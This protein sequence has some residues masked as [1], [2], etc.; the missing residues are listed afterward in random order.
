MDAPRPKRKHR[1]MSRDEQRAAGAAAQGR[2]TGNGVPGRYERKPYGTGSAAGQGQ[3]AWQAPGELPGAAARRGS[4]HSAGARPATGRHS[5]LSGSS[6]SDLSRYQQMRREREGFSGEGGHG[7]ARRAAAGGSPRGRRRLG[8]KVF[9]GVV[10]SLLVFVIGFSLVIGAHMGSGITAETR[11]ALTPSFPG[12]PF[13]MLLVGTD[14]SAEREATGATDGLYRTDSIMLTRVDPLAA[15][16]TLVSIQRDTLVDLGEYGKQKINAAYTFG[17]A[18]LLIKAVSELAGVGISHYAEID[19]DSFTSVVDALGGIDVNVPIDLDDELAGLHVS[20]GE[21]TIDGATALGLCRARHAYDSYGSGDYFRTANQRMVLGAIL[22]KALSGNPV[23]LFATINAA[24]DS[25]TT[26]LTG[27]DF[28]FLGLRFLGFN[29]A[30]DLYSG[31]EPT[32]SSYVNG[33]WYELLDTTSWQAMMSRVD[34]GLSPYS[35][36][37]QDPTAG[38]AGA[39]SAIA[40]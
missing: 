13:Y 26:D 29:M 17:G 32:K 30:E 14:K 3:K 4:G 35:D 40:N 24:T 10:A 12:Q 38:L 15:K 23:S 18:P 5:H 6:A 39:S 27:L 33:T 8:L 36:A 31:L 1:T 9:G 34:R 28:I 22:K 2:V 21:Q 37:S 20:A 16:V 19:F 7:G 11:T 25:V